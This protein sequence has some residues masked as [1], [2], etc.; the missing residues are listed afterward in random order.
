MV[1]CTA[2]WGG[3]RGLAVGLSLCPGHSRLAALCRGH[4][5][6][7]H[8]CRQWR[9]RQAVLFM[10]DSHRKSTSCSRA[11]SV[12]P[13]RTPRVDDSVPAHHSLSCPTSP[14][15]DLETAWSP[16]FSAFV[17]NTAEQSQVFIISVHTLSLSVCDCVAPGAGSRS[18]VLRP[19]RYVTGHT[20]VETRPRNS[21]AAGR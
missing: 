2:N 9:G 17:R 3:G 21:Q 14:M 18:W 11:S 10:L 5:R 16:S 7:G 13:P 1:T 8:P 12:C 19:Q 20:S 6:R 4:L 15:T